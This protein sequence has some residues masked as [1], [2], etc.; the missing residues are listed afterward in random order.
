MEEIRQHPPLVDDTELMEERPPRVAYVILAVSFLMLMASSG[1][2]WFGFPVILP[3]MLNA[4]D[5]SHSQLGLIG[6][7]FF[8]GNVAAAT[9]MG[10]LVSRLPF[11][12][13]APLTVALMGVAFVATALVPSLWM[14]V[15]LQV[16]AGVGSVG[17][18]ICGSVMA[19]EWFPLRRRGLV[20]GITRGGTGLGL[21]LSGLMLPPIIEA[22][23]DDGWRYG[24][25]AIGATI[26]L[27][28]LLASL[29]VRES[30]VRHIATEAKGERLRETWAQVMAVPA[31]WQFAVTMF[32]FGIGAMLFATFFVTFLIQDRGLTPTLAGSL[33][34]VVGVLGIVGG[35]LSGVASDFIGRRRATAILFLMQVVGILAVV[36]WQ[37]MGVY[38]L[39]VFLY[40]ISM[41]G[42]PTTT[43]AAFLDYVGP[44]RTPVALSLV[45]LCVLSGRALGPVIGGVIADITEALTI[46]F[47][48]AVAVQIIG[49]VIII[50][51]FRTAALLKSSQPSDSPT[52]G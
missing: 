5:V 17:A 36:V 6:T 20:I 43:I 10:T 8:I 12:L 34:A 3:S 51:P 24:W 35:P 32:F 7:A 40:G 46:P 52:H 47:V 4:L 23:G 41:N 11:R 13:M 48:V 2:A 50:L 37:G 39:V 22:G 15:A 27:I 33:W 19:N 21:V 45:V 42:F 26:L 1:L 49:L 38:L 31:V 44:R 16:V 9:P 14:I 25:L 18:T 30:P 29:L 28:A